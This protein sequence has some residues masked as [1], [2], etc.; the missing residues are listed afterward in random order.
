M[1]TGQARVP[2]MHPAGQVE[3]TAA[4]RM[5]HLIRELGLDATPPQDVRL[6]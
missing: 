6:P 3:D 1:I 4:V 5:A 2:M